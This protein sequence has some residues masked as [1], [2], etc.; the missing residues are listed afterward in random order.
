[1]AGMYEELATDLLGQVN[2]AKVDV[3]ANRDLGRRFDVAG[4]PTLKFLRKGM[5]YDYKGP[6]TIEALKDFV[7]GGYASSEGYRTPA[8]KGWLDEMLASMRTV[9][10]GFLRLLSS[11]REDI[12]G[13]KY[14]SSPV[15]MTACLLFILLVAFGSC[16]I[17]A[18][19]E[20]IRY[21]KD[22]SGDKEN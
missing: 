15:L 7:K 14:T 5:T 10:E 6:R 20:E 16:L 22:R 18:S 1:M 3:P 19:E 2:V 21:R 13:G 9:Q 12:M 17:P 4:F 8:S 11:A